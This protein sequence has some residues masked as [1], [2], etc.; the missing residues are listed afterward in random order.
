MS[1]Y[2]RVGSSHVALLFGAARC[3]ACSDKLDSHYRFDGTII[4][5]ST[6]VRAGIASEE[7]Q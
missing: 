6:R 2:L 4:A 3:S 7:L 5:C 1:G